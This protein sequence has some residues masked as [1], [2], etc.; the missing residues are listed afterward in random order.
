LDP[1]PKKL[2]A[3]VLRQDAPK[4]SGFHA[5]SYYFSTIS[6]HCNEPL[7][8]FP[9]APRIRRTR[10]PRCSRIRQWGYRPSILNG[11]PVKIDILITVIY[12][13]SQ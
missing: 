10:K 11:Q 6:E 2:D 13:L 1:R 7:F 9:A 4:N 12:T 3:S 5:V 8:H